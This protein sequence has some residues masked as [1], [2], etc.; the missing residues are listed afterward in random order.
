MITNGAIIVGLA[1]AGASVFLGRRLAKR[2][3]GMSRKFRLMVNDDRTGRR[4][5]LVVNAPSE[6][7]AIRIAAKDRLTVDQI[8]EIRSESA[9]ED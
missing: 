4:Q 7:A 3:A 2:K 8:E 9:D 1:I 5:T 6:E